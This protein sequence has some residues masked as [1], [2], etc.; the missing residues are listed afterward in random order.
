MG[1]GRPFLT[2]QL[3]IRGADSDKV[4]IAE[5]SYLYYDHDG[6]CLV[7]VIFC[8]DGMVEQATGRADMRGGWC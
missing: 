5:H 2:H 4:L 7:A 8:H 1:F 6:A 3:E